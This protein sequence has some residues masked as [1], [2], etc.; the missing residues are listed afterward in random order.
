[1]TRNTL[2]NPFNQRIVAKVEMAIWKAMGFRLEDIQAKDRHRHLVYA[3][4][5]FAHRCAREK[6]EHNDIAAY[7]GRERTSTLYFLKKHDDEFAHN[8]FFREL[9]KEVERNINEADEEV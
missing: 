1:M 5:I 9:V 4:M 3:R 8:R 6:M 2:Q 7:L